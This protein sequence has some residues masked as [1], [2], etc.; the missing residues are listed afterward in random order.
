[1][2]E[3][4]DPDI[5]GQV[6]INQIDLLNILYLFFSQNIESN[7]FWHVNHVQTIYFTK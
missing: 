6:F 3:M 1:M 2:N 5:S 7:G 4:Y